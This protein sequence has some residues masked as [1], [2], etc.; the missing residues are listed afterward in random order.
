MVTHSHTQPLCSKIWRVRGQGIPSHHGHGCRRVRAIDEEALHAS[1]FSFSC[2][3]SYLGGEGF[4]FN[5]CTH[6]SPALGGGWPMTHSPLEITSTSAQHSRT[7]AAAARHSRSVSMSCPGFTVWLS[8]GQ[9]KDTRV[10]QFQID[11]RCDRFTREKFLQ[12]ARLGWVEDETEPFHQTTRHH[13]SMQRT[14]DGAMRKGAPTSRCTAQPRGTDNGRS[15]TTCFCA[16]R[17]NQQSESMI[18][19]SHHFL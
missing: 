4:A 1:E 16:R 7:L 5:T 6:Y 9:K 3:I 14:C 15:F 11:V 18:Q 17:W 8:E 13:H 12:G 19:S 10:T 2:R